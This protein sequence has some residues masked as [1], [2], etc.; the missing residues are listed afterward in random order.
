MTKLKR[1]VKT[2]TIPYSFGQ[3]KTSLYMRTFYLFLLLILFLS[4]CEKEFTPEISTAPPELVV[5]GY[6]E[7]GENPTP[8][9]VILTQSKP[10]FGEL[11]STSFTDLYVHDAEVTITS[12]DTIYPLT[13]ICLQDLTPIQKVFVKQFLGIDPD[14]IKAN[15][16]MYL[17]MTFQ[18]KGRSGGRYDLKIVS[19]GQTHEATTTI[20]RMVPLDSIN[21]KPLPGEQ[22]QDY[23]ELHAY[24]HDLGDAKDYWRYF[25]SINDSS[26][27]TAS[28]SIYDDGFISGQKLEFVMNN[29]QE[30]AEGEDP[31]TFGLF[32]L[33]DT[34]SLKWTTIDEAHYKF[35]KTAEFSKSQG[36]FS[37]YVRIKGNVSD[38]LGVWGGYNVQYLH[39]IVK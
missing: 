16:C 8:A 39:K 26:Y 10:F 7:G 29:G 28:F 5:E 3:L 1:L 22:F 13:E 34:L 36:P 18:L 38:A 33:G 25:T 20:P 37:S 30:P 35:R 23:R 31:F 24:M 14:S 19:D 21:F 32:K 4:A 15:I 17:D 9:Y 11:D 6:I 27:V 2:I 12:N